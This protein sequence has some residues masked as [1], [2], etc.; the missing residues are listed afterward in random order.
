MP[1]VPDVKNYDI[2]G[3]FFDKLFKASKVFVLAGAGISTALGIQVHS[4]HYLIADF[5]SFLGF[6]W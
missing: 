1:L 2:P 3:L 6:S 4:G 5:N